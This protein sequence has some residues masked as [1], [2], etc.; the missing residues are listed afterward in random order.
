M[1]TILASLP[2][3]LSSVGLFLSV[4]IVLPAFTAALLPLTVGAPEI[5][6]WLMAGNA[7]AIAITVSIRA[8]P[9]WKGS[10]AIACLAFTLSCLPLVQLPL[11]VRQ[12]SS[13]LQPTIGD[14]YFPAS[15]S[16]P[17][18]AFRRH[19]FTIL[20]SIRGIPT[21][22]VIHESAIPFATPAGE[23]LA[24]DI[25]RPAR[26]LPAQTVVLNPTL[27][28]IYG[29]AW[30][31]GSPSNNAEFNRYMASQ[32][33]TVVALDYRHAPQF[34]F[35]AQIEDVWTALA[36]IDER[37]E[38]YNIDRD[39]L[40]VLG[41]SAGAQLAMLLAY[42]KE[43]PIADLPP[44]R[45]VVSFYGPV[46]LASGYR[47]PPIPDPIDT[48]QTLEI[49]LGGSPDEVPELYR[50]ASPISYV[51]P[52]LPPSLLI[53]GGRDLVVKAE[54]GRELAQTLE[55][56]GN[57]VAWIEIPWADHA[58]DTIF[59]GV[60]SQLSLYYIERFLAWALSPEI[61]SS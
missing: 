23:E 48:R 4:W 46:N 34:R 2:V 16:Q 14:T 7:I 13:D 29:G 6:P 33:Y 36:W 61:L 22:D 15:S 49:F 8:Y 39:R 59:N 32:G 37:A 44:I 21:A 11:V 47:Q 40:A 50:Q 12:L 53:Y 52:N 10:V 51:R 54:Y 26:E 24:L 25:Y 58:F 5:S 43:P 60:S 35:P 41:R 57:T 42:S 20:D 30:Q 28:T 3:I 17:P 45:A 55:A 18:T 27:I 56:T 1:S 38:R 19:P 31:R 9:F